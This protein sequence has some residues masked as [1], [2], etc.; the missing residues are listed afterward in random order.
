M[1][2]T[3]LVLGATSGI[4]RALCRR[5]AARGDHLVLAARDGE[6]L[7]TLAADLVTRGATPPETVVFDA[8]D[9]ADL[10]ACFARC[11]DAAGGR[12]DGVVLCFGTL[13]DQENAFREPEAARAALEV[14]LVAPVVLLNLAASHLEDAGRGWI[15]AISSV[16]GDRGRQSNFIYGSA[17]AGLSAYL[18]G[19]RN[20]LA[21]K[22]VHVLTVKPGFVD[23]AMTQGVVDPRSPLLASPDKVA[24]DIERALR[25][26]RDVLFTPWFW[27]PIMLVIRLIP[28]RIFK[29]LHL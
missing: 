1:S 21:A 19:L 23:T 11:L 7:A 27:R 24:R 9:A 26:R 3:I 8:G 10:P 28:E 18:S 20:R 14:N 22:G 2:E 25:R 15:A 17:K 4:A 6:T 5:L 16:A 13:P 29:R 12:L